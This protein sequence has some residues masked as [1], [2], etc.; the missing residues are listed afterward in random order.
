M[1]YEIFWGTGNPYS[2]SVLLGL[3]IK[4]LK[5]KSKLLE[6]SKREHLSPEILEMNPRGQL[7][8]LKDGEISIYESIAILAYLDSKHPEIPLFGTTPNE[9]GYIWQR[10]FEIE[11]YLRDKIL[12]IVHPI[13]FDDVTDNIDSI[14]KSASYVKSEFKILEEQLNK[15]E[16]LSG[17]NISA[18]DIILFPLVKTLFRAFT[19]KPAE[20]LDLEIRNLNKNYPNIAN[21]LIRIES[22][23]G[24]ENTYPPNWKD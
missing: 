18:V 12:G 11:N 4:S 7:P 24:Y 6:F 19:M 2:W 14:E 8:I 9:I 22:T 16:F 13:F 20:N 21:W 3:E 10:V 15:L 23:A 1:S 17:E 5:Y